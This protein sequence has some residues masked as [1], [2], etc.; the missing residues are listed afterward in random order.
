MQFGQQSVPDL[1]GLQQFSGDWLGGVKID[2]V[3]MIS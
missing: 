2:R 1:Q 3:S